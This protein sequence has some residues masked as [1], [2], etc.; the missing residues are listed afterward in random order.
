MINMNVQNQKMEQVTR[1]WVC[2]GSSKPDPV[3]FNGMWVQT[4]L[5]PFASTQASFEVRVLYYTTF[6]SHHHPGRPQEL[7]SHQ[8]VP[9]V[10]KYQ[11]VAPEARPH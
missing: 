2:A 3:G 1:G 5:I 8:S 10:W 7:Q 4:N 11:L 6:T 9:Q